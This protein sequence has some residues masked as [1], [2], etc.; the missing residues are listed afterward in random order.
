MRAQV[1][2]PHRTRRAAAALGLLALAAGGPAMAQGLDYG[3]LEALFEEPVTTSATGK[4]QRASE[5]PVAM[6][7]I[8]A[9]QIR[10]SGAHDI[11]TV[12]AR[13]TSLDVQQY[14]EHD[15]S[16]G[17]RGLTTQQNSRLLV[18]VDGRQVYFDDYG[19]TDWHMIPVQ[20]GEIRQIEV[21]RGPNTALFGFNAVAGVI[22][23]VTLNPAYDRVNN[24]TVRL[25]THGYKEFS[26]VA[27]APLGDGGGVRLSAG[28]RD[29]TPWLSGFLPGESGRD[30]RSEPERYQ[31]AANTVAKVAEGVQV[32]L[33][34]SYA[35]SL[36]PDLALTG[37][38]TRFDTR[39]FSIRGRVAAET[40]IGLVEAS[41]YHNGLDMTAR[42]L[43]V[44][45]NQAVTVLQLSDTVKLG[46]SHT[47]R[48]SF[49]FR[50]NA[51]DT[52]HGSIVGYKVAAFGAMWDWAITD[53]LDLTLAGRRDQVWLEGEGYNSPVTPNR[54]ALYDRAFGTFGYNAGLVWR[55]TPDDSV[56]L[57]ASRGIGMPSLVDLGL[58]MVYPQFSYV[59]NPNLK[60]TVVDNY[61][62]GYRRRVAALDA[63]FGVTAFHQV[64]RDMSSTLFALRPARN[65]GIRGLSFEARTIPT[66]TV[67]GLELSGKGKLVH[68][69]DWGVE[70]RLAAV[71]GD[72]DPTV[73]FDPKHAS[74]RHLVSSRLG[75]GQ[76]PFQAD[77]FLRYASTA[78][79]WRAV[80]Q[81]FTYVT[82]DDYASAGAR[83]AYR[84]AER[85][86]LALEGSN[87]LSEKQ[88][89]SI[90]LEARRS[91]YG[92]LRVDF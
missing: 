49:E 21:V 1:P 62:I 20:L 67:S 47:L 76:G 73:T 3:A 66:L 79:G 8:T 19:R 68:G 15:F 29:S 18:L 71:A 25:G 74:P 37:M 56:R 10:R 85:F 36:A 90:G 75:W 12:L 55:P 92:S 69:F 33:D 35:R 2:A 83:I 13:Y 30:L 88:R 89:Q 51:L 84:F 70:Y 81:K 77:L 41:A 52:G 63:S 40:G 7:I 14:N 72:L 32:S 22:N 46:A 11:P 26:G 91:V 42:S 48:P 80:S 53:T 54:N 57:T 27:T 50:H 58:Q 28:A 86:T 59:G 16:V 82:V 17:V 31:F 24:A 39:A 87:L 60:P 45:I 9:E 43:S 44:A 65:P 34:G 78:G 23:I 4:P 6:D 61:E 5:V 38:L 64:N